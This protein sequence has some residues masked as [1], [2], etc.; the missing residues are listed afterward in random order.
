MKSSL[1]NQAKKYNLKF[2]L[3]PTFKTGIHL[4]SVTT[5][6]I[7]LTKKEITFSGAVLDTTTRIRGLFNKYVVDLLTSEQ[8][9]RAIDLENEFQPRSIEVLELRGRNEK[10]QQ[11]TI[12]KNEYN[13]I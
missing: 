6:E 9:I 7:G 11:Y 5:G 13:T 1:S 10:I 8:V 12:V 4:G 3:V 2:G